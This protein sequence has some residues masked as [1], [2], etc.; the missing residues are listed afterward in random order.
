VKKRK[1]AKRARVIKG[2]SDLLQSPTMLG[3]EVASVSSEFNIY[4]HRSIQTAVLGTVETVYKP[5]ALVE[6]NDLEFVMPGDS[7]NYIDL[8][9]K[10][11]VRGK[12][13]SNSGKDVD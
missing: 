3:A 4:V 11:Y 7:D 13:V 1:K 10:L 9:I 5:L 12:L 2:T 6:Q 8:D